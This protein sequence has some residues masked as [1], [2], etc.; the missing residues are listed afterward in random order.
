MSLR[1]GS[2][3]IVAHHAAVQR[4]LHCLFASQESSFGGR[5]SQARPRVK[6]GGS[7]CWWIRQC[8]WLAG[9]PEVRINAHTVVPAIVTSESGWSATMPPGNQNNWTWYIVPVPAGPWTL[10]AEVELP[11][12]EA[13]ISAWFMRSFDLPS[14]PEPLQVAAGDPALPLPPFQVS[15]AGRLQSVAPFLT[16]VAAKKIE[17]HRCRPRRTD[18]RHLPGPP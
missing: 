13:R 12:P 1:C 7:T 11:G 17:D 15:A 14:P 8:R 3:L 16:P 10:D 18:Q 5:N 2:A 6:D 4:R 9:E